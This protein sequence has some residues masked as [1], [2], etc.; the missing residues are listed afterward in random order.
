[1]PMAR[2][3]RPQLAG[4]IYHSMGRGNNKMNIFID[5]LDRFRFLSILGKVTAKYEV[6]CWTSCLM[7]NHYHLILR[8][9]QANVSAAM[10]QLNG[11]YAQ[12]W[13][14]RHARVGHVFQGRFK[15]Q[16]VEDGIYLLRACRYVMLNPVRGG[17]CTTPDQWLWS[18]YR[19]LA[20][21]TT[22]PSYLD[23]DSLLQRLGGGH[24]VDLRSR[25]IEFVN[26]RS[27]EAMAKFF[28]EDTRVIGSEEFAAQFQPTA[29]IGSREVP[30]RERRIGTPSLARILAGAIES[31]EG[32]SIGIVRAH[33]DFDYPVEDIARCAGLS[34]K[35]VMKVLRSRA[36]EATV[37]AVEWA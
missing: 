23:V 29:L 28:R 6:D 13:N 22:S 9:R 26:D 31:A 5:D 17:L 4:L 36:P 12:W 16:I 33:R 27:D 32:L 37:T 20:G 2:P 34:P 35:T 10:R 14:K 7:G 25:L 19:A 15:G 11:V 3:L 1:M 30:A 21:L 18:S 24:V 8:T